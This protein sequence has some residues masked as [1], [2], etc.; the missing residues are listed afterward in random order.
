MQ[1]DD[2]A[3]LLA[4][5]ADGSAIADV[6]ARSHVES[7]LRCQADLVQY[8]K[9]L[10]ALHNLRTEVLEPA[11]G[12]LPGILANLE[13]AGERH[14]VR[15]MLTGRRLAYAGGIAAATAAGAAGALLYA[16]RGKR[17][18]AVAS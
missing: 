16:T 2:I 14:A 10:R 11:P 3:D 9:L 12:V 18:R 17:T 13:R 1:C 6:R 7:C 15:S 4:E 5:V 8:R